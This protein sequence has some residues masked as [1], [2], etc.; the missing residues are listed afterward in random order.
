MSPVKLLHKFFDSARLDVGLPD[1]F[2]IPVKPREWFLLPLGAIEEAIKK[3]KEGT[4]DQFR[5]DP[6]AA[7]LV[8][9]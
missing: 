7:K 5:Y 4:L 2:G 1:R 3:I 6:E 8:R 9:L